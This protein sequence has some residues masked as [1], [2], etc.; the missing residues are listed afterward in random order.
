LANLDLFNVGK[1]KG[2]DVLPIPGRL[3]FERPNTSAAVV[4]ED[5]LATDLRGVFQ[6]R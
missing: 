1:L 5:V 3:N 4:A 2:A 6:P